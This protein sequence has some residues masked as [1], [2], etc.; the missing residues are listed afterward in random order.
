MDLIPPNIEGLTWRSVT[1][2][3]LA[4]LSALAMECHAADGGL[5]FLSLPENLRE[6]CFPGSPG[7]ALGAFDSDSRLAGF[8]TVHLTQAAGKPL[9]V[10][11]GHVRPDLR[12]RG[13]G[14]YLVHWGAQTA[15]ELFPAGNDGILRVA[16]EALTEP[17]RRLYNAYGFVC[18]FEELVMRRDL[19]AS[20]PDQPFP[21]DLTLSTWTPDIAGQFFEAYHAAFRERPGFPG[22]TAQEWITGYMENENLRPDWS[23]LACAGGVP[24]GFVMASTEGIPVGTVTAD[25]Y[26]VQVGVVPSQRRRRL[27]SALLVESMRRM[28]AE[29]MTMAQLCVHINNPG[30]IKAYESIGFKE[31]G[32][33][34][35]FERTELSL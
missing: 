19:T 27:A 20:L 9:A 8:E 6:R 25:G 33:R 5:S 22:Y 4:A 21:E 28:E 16:T 34:G 10:L 15:K 13:L 1:P 23:L 35:R 26:I 2:N 14:H 24:V 7:A 29:G 32:R 12:G 18:T 30:A 17:A 31:S 11:T 3:D